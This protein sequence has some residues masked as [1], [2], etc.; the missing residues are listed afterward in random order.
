MGSALFEEPAQEMRFSGARIALD[1]QP[2]G[3]Q[4]LEV[5]KRRSALWA[6]AHLDA[7]RHRPSRLI[8]M[9]AHLRGRAALDRPVIIAPD[10]C[11]DGAA[12]TR[13]RG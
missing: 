1:E 7:K 6:E 2:G 3:E 10:H 8:R 9:M 5:E 13:P 11:G 12:A 4:F